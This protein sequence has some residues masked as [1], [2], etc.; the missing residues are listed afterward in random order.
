[1]SASAFCVVQI[2]MEKPKPDIGFSRELCWYPTPR[3]FQNGRSYLILHVVEMGFAVILFIAA[4]AVNL[5]QMD[6]DTAK[7]GA[8]RLEADDVEDRLSDEYKHA[9]AEVDSSRHDITNLVHRG[10][11]A[12][13][14]QLQ[15]HETNSEEEDEYAE[16][17]DGALDYFSQPV[18]SKSLLVFYYFFLCLRN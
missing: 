15:V 11:G 7:H 9:Q 1:M 18:E 14:L 2:V 4:L 6:I 8:S 17:E 12:S 3:M 13:R 16:E 10:A 5:N